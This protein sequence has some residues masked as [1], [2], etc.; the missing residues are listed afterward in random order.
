M[1][2]WCSPYK[3]VAAV[4]KCASQA[5]QQWKFFSLVDSEKVY[6]YWFEHWNLNL[7][8]YEDF[9][10]KQLGIRNGSLIEIDDVNEEVFSEDF[11]K[12]KNFPKISTP[13]SSSGWGEIKVKNEELGWNIVNIVTSESD[14]ASDVTMGFEDLFYDSDDSRIKL[15]CDWS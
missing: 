5:Q 8:D 14:S 2:G 12:T 10:L 6:N 3:R 13:T 15:K 1:S 4:S 7:E 11:L 9:Y